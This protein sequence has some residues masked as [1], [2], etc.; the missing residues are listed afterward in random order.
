[1]FFRGRR[2]QRKRRDLPYPEPLGEELRG[3]SEDQ[4]SQVN[5]TVIA[6]LAPSLPSQ[7]YEVIRDQQDLSAAVT[8]VGVSP[9]R[10]QIM[11]RV[12]AD[13]NQ[14]MPKSYW[15]YDSVNITWGV[16]ENYEIVRKIGKSPQS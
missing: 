11:A 4:P 12:Y 6:I 13:V 1:M 14:H 9:E 15:E 7:R 16:L 10:E 8:V 5:I 3:L 2:L